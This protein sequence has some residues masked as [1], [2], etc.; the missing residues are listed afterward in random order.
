MLKSETK[1]NMVY[2]YLKQAFGFFKVGGF[3]VVI[4][5]VFSLIG[6][7]VWVSGKYNALGS[8]TDRINTPSQ[9]SVVY[10]RNG[11][12][13]FRYYDAGEKREIVP[14]DQIPEVMQLAVIAMEDENFYYNEDGIPWSNLVGSA[15]KC[16]RPGYGECR[17]GSG[18][19]QQLIKKTITNRTYATFDNK[20]DEL[21]GAY[22]FNQEV[23]K[24][25]V[26]RLYLNVVPFGRNTYGVEEASKSYF[27][28]SIGEK[29]DGKFTLTVPEACFIGS[30]LPKPEGF[31]VGIREKLDGKETDDWITLKARQEACI[32][33]LGTQQIAPT[34][35]GT[36][37]SFTDIEK[38]KKEEVKF[39][40]YKNEDVKFGH[41]K[42]FITQE[43][44]GRF[45]NSG[46]TNPYGFKNESDLLT[47]GLRIKTTFDLNIQ[48]E[49]EETTKK[50]VE[51][52]VKPNGGNNSASIVLDGPSGQILGMVGSADFNNK[53]IDGE[54]NMITSARQP[55]SSIKPFVYASAFNNGFNPSTVLLD[56]AIDFGG[57]Y[58]P[59]NFD[60]TF[61]GP[62]SM[63]YALQNS[64]NIPAVKA[65]YLSS[66][67]T[68]TPDGNGGLKNFKKFLDKT[69]DSFPYWDKGVCGVATALGGCEVKILDHATGIN[70][71]LQEG[72]KTPATP[73]LEI[74]SVDK[75]FVTGENTTQDLYN[76][77]TNG[78]NNPYPKI[79]QAIDPN[80]ARQTA[81][82]LS[83]YA[84][85]DPKVWGNTS[86]NLILKDWTG[87]NQIAAKTGTTN[88]YKD[89]WT[90]GGSPYFTVVT[91]AGNTDGKPMSDKVASASITGPIWHDIMV[92]LHKDKTK[93]GFSR[94]GLEQFT[95]EGRKPDL[96]TKS[97]IQKEKEAK[98]PTQDQNSI[99]YTRNPFAVSSVKV[100]KL[101]GKLIPEGSELPEYLIENINCGGGGS[102][103]PSAPNW[104]G[105]N[106]KTCPT[107][108]TEMTK[109][110]AKINVQTN[111]QSGQIAPSNLNVTVNHPGGADKVQLIELRIDG[112]FIGS[113]QNT[114]SLNA[115]VNGL[116]GSKEIEILIR[117]NFGIEQKTVYPGVFF[118]GTTGS[119]FV[120]QTEE[121][122]IN[123]Q[124][125]LLLPGQ[126]CRTK[127]IQ[128]TPTNYNING[129]LQ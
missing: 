22:K 13:M 24:Q 113:T 83:D 3:V 50:G 44:I 124:K 112:Q 121:C 56:Q 51:N 26:L 61:N 115:N 55:G 77:A 62:V 114:N 20:V 70:T 18:L 88:D 127:K 125:T 16:L 38:Y 73:F 60:K 95:V 39:L 106:G 84:A 4:L 76:L 101:D 64:L 81:N 25:D 47:R 111:F 117:D 79:E 19:S 108:K 78:P 32:E 52:N 48:N 59:L 97:Q 7:G 82:V 75:N 91:W 33:K 58:K 87:E 109:D 100:N 99:F 1:P 116:Y 65:L 17:G 120:E 68:N 2:F 128:S 104:G 21:L 40:P 96:L 42:N 29:K 36:F 66:D 41:I 92:K 105:T 93:K 122:F 63:R 37:I 5:L 6:A 45:K 30:M 12:E 27:G 14:I 102:E 126:D 80:I 53:D 10:D 85:R 23:T 8:I 74:I 118:G 110:N 119:S 123:G 31:A 129:L 86:D 54:V 69:G 34:D 35:K 57:N 107:E 46:E 67:P 98:K 72:K 9:G 90:V 103:F 11:Q 71:L 94:E 43:L 15:L 28:K 49:L 89:A